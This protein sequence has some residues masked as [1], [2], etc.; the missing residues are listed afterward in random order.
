MVVGDAAHAMHPI[1]SM[2]VNSGLEDAYL[3]HL[4]LTGRIDPEARVPKGVLARKH[5]YEAGEAPARVLSRA[6]LLAAVA[7]F[8]AV[9]GP[10]VR[11]L[12]STAH[13]RGRMR[14]FKV[15]DPYSVVVEGILGRWLNKLIPEVI[16]VNAVRAYAVGEKSY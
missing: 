4:F 16:P 1:T 14:Q 10:E 7:G 8:S 9:R 11:A 2:G 3:L 5:F 13:V 15:N 6:E 12:T